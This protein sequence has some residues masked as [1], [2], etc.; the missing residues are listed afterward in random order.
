M[1]RL[2]LIVSLCAALAAA[3][4]LP[5]SA[6]DDDFIEINSEAG[7]VSYHTETG[8]ATV[9]NGFVARYQGVVLSAEYGELNRA[10]GDMI[11]QGSVYLQSE[12]QIWRGDQLRYNLLNR[13]MGAETFRTGRPPFFAAAEGLTA[14]LTND[15][16]TATGAYL[17]TDDVAQPGLRIH[18]K[19]IRIA[20]GKYVEARHAVLY[21]GKLPVFYLPYVRYNLD[22]DSNHWSLTPGYRSIYGPFLLGGY[23]WRANDDVSGVFHLDYRVK[24]GLAGGPDVKY[25][26][27]RYGEGDFKFYYLYDIDPEAT[28]TSST[29]VSIPHNRDRLYFTHDVTIR[30]NLDARLVLRHQSDAYVTRDFLESEYRENPQ[31]SSFLEVHQRWPNFSLG[32][33][34]QPQVNDFLDTVER[35]PDLKLTALRQQLGQ[36]PLFYE[37]ESSVGY[38]RRNYAD[39]SLTNDYSAFRADT[40]H[41]VLLPLNLFGWLNLAPR[42]GGRFT[43]YGETDGDG[44][45]LTDQDRWVFNTGAELSFKASRVWHEPQSKLLEIDGLRHIVQ[46]A[47]NFVYVPEPSVRPPELPQFDTELPSLRLLPI[48]FP[49]YN[50]IDSIDARNVVRLGLRNKLQTKRDGQVDN[51]VNWSLYTDWRL[52]RLPGQSTFADLFSDLDF[53]PRSWLTLTSEL[54]YG[55][56][57]GQIRISQHY[58]TL[59]PNNRWSWMLG[60]RYVR[61]DPELGFTIGNNLFTSSFYY[62]LNDNW[63]TRLSHHFEAQDG[64]LEEQYYTLYRDFRSWTAAFTFRVRDNRDEGLDYG[65]AFTFSLKAFPRFGL[66]DDLNKPSLLLGN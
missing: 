2:R 57:S 47:F 55:V 1:K 65:A 50:S 30:T 18:A 63:G 14:D 19:T 49:D 56:D 4:S 32:L 58:L 26:A 15:L 10:T 17:T 66:G 9:T 24:R 48:D 16:Y 11:L 8:I 25:D 53:R 51:L 28:S 33:T 3:G 12:D 35:L 46:P 44:S 5:L 40:Y 27:G 42:V 37:A 20:P 21:A 29:N 62:R 22:G 59:T 34:A 64:T 43:H 23:H 61:E 54:R 39:E 60:H 31:P 6:A 45:T 41:E 52:D 38:F 13:Q 36:S 7:A